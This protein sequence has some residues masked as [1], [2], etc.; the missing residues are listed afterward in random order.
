[1]QVQK[2]E[3]ISRFVKAFQTQHV[4]I[5]TMFRKFAWRL[6]ERFMMIQFVSKVRLSSPVFVTIYRH[7]SENLKQESMSIEGKMSTNKA[8]TFLYIE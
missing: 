3:Y 4:E 6:W 1:M 8:V 7:V 5:N 2:Y